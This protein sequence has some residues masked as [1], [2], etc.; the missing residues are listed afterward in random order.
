MYRNVMTIVHVKGENLKPPD[1][2]VTV[3]C[4]RFAHAETIYTVN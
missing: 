2:S 4:D 3:T 1:Q